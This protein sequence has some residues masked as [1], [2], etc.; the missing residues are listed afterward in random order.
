MSRSRRVAS[1]LAAGLLCATAGCSDETPADIVLPPADGDERPAI[2]E[3]GQLV[4]AQRSE[5]HVGD[6]TFTV[7]KQIVERVDW[8]PYGLFLRLTRDPLMGPSTLAFHDGTSL[9]QIDDV[10]RNEVV[11]S[12]DGELVAWI[13][14][15]GPERPAGRVAEVVVIEVRTGEVVFRSAE[16]MGGEKG[17]DLPVLYGELPPSVVELT[18]DKVVWM[19]AS[20]AGQSVTTDLAT[21]EST[22]TDGYA[23]PTT[24][25]YEYSSP[26]GRHRVD[27]TKTYRLRVSPRQP[28]FGHK[29]VTQGGWLG[30]HQ[31]LALGQDSFKLSYNPRKPDKTPGYILSCDLDAGTCEELERIVG[32][33]DVVFAGVDTRY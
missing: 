7:G 15:D 30:D 33:R 22:R 14:R 6:T 32:A 20:G 5:I 24:S 3:P 27:A 2:Y 21:D 8:T 1:L 23:R 12:P 28:D 19:N 13:N 11:T 18:A 10:F 29:W 26:D 9:T 4:W 16:G 17:D 31:L 25:G